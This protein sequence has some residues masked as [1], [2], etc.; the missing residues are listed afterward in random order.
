MSVHQLHPTPQPPEYRFT[1]AGKALRTALALIEVAG[2]PD[3]GNVTVHG[4]GQ[5]VT[6]DWTGKP[7]AAAEVACAAAACGLLIKRTPTET[8]DGCAAV[9]HRATDYLDGILRTFRADVPVEATWPT[10]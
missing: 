3:T 6:F 9:E 4:E 7:H 5:N 8:A 1:P 10:S 2:V